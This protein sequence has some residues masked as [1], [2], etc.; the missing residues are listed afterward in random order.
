MTYTW[1]MT[2]DH[3]LLLLENYLFEYKKKM[4]YIEQIPEAHQVLEKW[5]KS[6]REERICNM[7]EPM[8]IEE[9]LVFL[10]NKLTRLESGK[11]DCEDDRSYDNNTYLVPLEKLATM[12]LK[13]LENEDNTC[14]QNIL[15]RLERIK[16]KH[17]ELTQT[18]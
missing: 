5:K 13:R 12:E 3:A 1:M 2:K 14:H 8:W 7:S 6:N 15:T 17:L 10:Q 4:G 9:L 11:N 18:K 16:Q